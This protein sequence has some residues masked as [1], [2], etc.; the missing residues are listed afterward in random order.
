MKISVICEVFESLFCVEC[1]N[2]NE[3]LEDN[4]DYFECDDCN[5]HICEE[6]IM[7]DNFATCL[8]KKRCIN[9]A[10]AKGCQYCDILRIVAD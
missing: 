10:T 3:E 6:C 7:M 8:C 4:R 5:N 9:C 1:K 2:L